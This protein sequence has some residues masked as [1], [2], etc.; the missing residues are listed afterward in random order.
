MLPLKFND[1]L[2]LPFRSE[3][4]LWVYGSD[5]EGAL[6]IEDARCV[7]PD[8]SGAVYI[9]SSHIHGDCFVSGRFS[10]KFAL[11]QTEVDGSLVL[12]AGSE[13]TTFVVRK[14]GGFGLDLSD[15]RVRRTLSVD[16]RIED[17]TEAGLLAGVRAR[18]LVT[19]TRRLPLS[20]YPGWWLVGGALRGSGRALDFNFVDRR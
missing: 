7:D 19:R 5:I 10:G 11:G 12:G 9:R 20:F 18:K 16:L 4:S 3:A 1:Q 2:T 8:E 14:D 15:L 17:A 6:L 13:P